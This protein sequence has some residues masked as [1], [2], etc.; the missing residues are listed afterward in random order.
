MSGIE[1]EVIDD[2]NRARMF[3]LA[4]Q[5]GA[6]AGQQ[7]LHPERLRQVVVGAAVDRVD[8]L[9]PAVPRGQDEYRHC[10]P[11]RPPALQDLDAIELWQSEV[12]HNEIIVLGIAPKPCRLA[13]ARLL[14]DIPGS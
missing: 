7:F 11:V 8:L 13:V 1:R 14:D 4:P 2:Q 3:G 12:E 6:H 10:A 5:Q 9:R